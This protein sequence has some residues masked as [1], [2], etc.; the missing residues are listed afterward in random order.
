MDKVHF[1][2]IDGE[3]LTGIFDD[4]K[5]PTDTCIIVCHGF[6]SSKDF[7]LIWHISDAIAQSGL[8]SF[9]FDFSGCGESEGEFRD[10]SYVKQKHDLHS[11]I[12]FVMKKGYKKIVLVGHSMGGA[13]SLMTAANDKRVIAVVDLAAPSH[14]ERD[15]VKKFNVAQHKDMEHYHF[16]LGSKKYT[17]SKRFVEDIS[18]AKIDKAVKSLKIPLLFVHGTEDSVVGHDQSQH[19][20]E[21]SSGKKKIEIIQGANHLFSKHMKEVSEIVSSWVISAL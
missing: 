7:K 3:S 10:S 14:P 4:P 1:T 20:F 19:L 13:V 11:A 6:A 17:L 16:I 5:K 18:E 2:N 15:F 8:C 12:D 21:I 9:R